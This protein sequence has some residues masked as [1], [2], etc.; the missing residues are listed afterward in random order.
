M[1]KLQCDTCDDLS[2]R[3]VWGEGPTKPKLIL[4][5]EAPGRDEDAEGRPFVGGAGRIL[6]AVLEEAH[7]RRSDVYITN[8]VKCRPPNNRTPTSVEGANCFGT[9]VDE[10]RGIDCGTIV[11][12][13]DYANKAIVDTYFGITKVRGTPMYSN[14]LRKNVVPTMHPAFV[15]RGNFEYIGILAGDIEKA[16]RIEAGEEVDP[17]VNYLVDPLSDE[18]R[19]YIDECIKQGCSCDIETTGLDPN[20]GVIL[21]VSF[22]HTPRSALYCDFTLHES[23]V[24]RI[25]ESG[26][27]ITFQYGQFDTYFLKVHGIHTRNWVFDTKYA[28]KLIAPELPSSLSFINSCYTMYPYY[29]EYGTGGEIRKNISATPKD[30]LQFYCNRDADVTEIGRRHLT[31]ELEENNLSSL[32]ETI[33]MPLAR[34]V[35]DIRINGFRIDIDALNEWKDTVG[36]NT[37]RLKAWFEERG[38]NP[39]SPTQLGTFLTEKHGLKLP[40]TPTGRWKT[41]AKTIRTLHKR[42]DLPI[43]D[44]LI[45]YR[46]VSK[47]NSTYIEAIDRLRNGD[48]LHSELVVGGTE[49]GR[50]SSRDPNLQNVPKDLRNIFIPEDGHTLIDADYRQLEMHVLSVLSEDEQLLSDLTN[51]V[52]IPTEIGKSLGWDIEKCESNKKVLKGVMY[53]TLYGRGARAIGIEFGIRTSDAEG[54]QRGF[55]R[56][57]PR[58]EEY[59]VNERRTATSTKRITTPFGRRRH[60]LGDRTATQSYNY[61]IQSCAADIMSTGLLRCTRTVPVKYFKLSVHDSGIFSVPTGELATYTARIKSALE[62]PIEQLEGFSFPAEI[63]TGKNWRDVK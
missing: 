13:G 42:Y 11:T 29:K 24:R 8:V 35:V 57:Y 31:D 20:N 48:R 21:G 18:G 53:G 55:L 45:K 52:Y 61:K 58:V 17:E 40:K 33:T 1:R 26:A 47:I 2:P 49:T 19:D 16:L 23:V 27:P 9:L 60:F 15:M 51:G 36:P 39:N 63:A 41:D 37:E 3:I 28:Q 7:L 6:N 50:L 25:L 44:Y 4:I 56:R 30:V 54:I 38:V 22:S 10:L 43:L 5:G 14:K 59:L 34:L 12:L 32:M 46:E 62:Q